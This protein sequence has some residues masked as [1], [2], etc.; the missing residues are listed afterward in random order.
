MKTLDLSHWLNGQA[1]L[2]ESRF[3]FGDLSDFG[4][5][6]IDYFKKEESIFGKLLNPKSAGPEDT[7]DF[8]IGPLAERECRTARRYL[9]ALD[10]LHECAASLWGNNE[11]PI[12]SAVL[13]KAVDLLN[14]P[15]IGSELNF[16]SSPI[17]PASNDPIR[18]ALYNGFKSMGSKPGYWIVVDIFEKLLGSQVLMS[19]KS[20][21]KTACTPVL[22]K[23]KKEGATSNKGDGFVLWFEVELIE[24]FPGPFVPDMASFGLTDISGLTEPISEVWNASGLNDEFRGRWR[25]T[26]GYPGKEK[27][28][29]E[30]KNEVYPA[31]LK[32]DSLQAAALA[33]IWAASGRIP[34]GAKSNE[35]KNNKPEENFYTL[36]GNSLRLN[37]RVAVSAR[38]DPSSAS[39]M[40]DSIALGAVKG[41]EAKTRGMKN[42]H[43][44]GNGKVSL[45]DTLI[46]VGGNAEETEN[47]ISEVE[48]NK[49]DYR[50]VRVIKDCRTMS[51]V[52]N[53]MLEV[54]AWKRAWNEHVE[55]KW[56]EQWGYA[57]DAD[58]FFLRKDA[59]SHDGDAKKILFAKPAEAKDG[60]WNEEWEVWLN[61]DS[62]R[63]IVLD[64]DTQEV[65]LQL[66]GEERSDEKT[67]AK[68]QQHLDSLPDGLRV[69]LES[70]VMR[71]GINTGSID[72]MKRPVGGANNDDMPDPTQTEDQN[73]KDVDVPG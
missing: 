46:V 2:L 1:E 56:L 7:P 28:F 11:T 50:G 25:I 45:F 5:S 63:F 72:Y 29:L 57:R 53:W 49:S 69:Y 33:A 13:E 43:P 39:L 51:H 9:K 62:G 20:E 60:K 52:L 22:F 70:I 38:I 6:F 65:T 8:F 14:V 54:N 48:Q 58:G 27:E 47:V 10:L 41:I 42:Y 44:D 16:D 68:L 19:D 18:A 30:F 12:D 31:S 21:L 4:R 61:E 26:A 24:D 3:V 17:E 23:Q 64:D 66:S 34:L 15:Y 36:D 55:Q 71:Q 40:N 35:D 59:D 73:I 32:D 37:P 67:V